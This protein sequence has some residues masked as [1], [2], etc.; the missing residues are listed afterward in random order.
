[1]FKLAA[2]MSKKLKSGRFFSSYEP[3]KKMPTFKSKWLN[4]KGQLQ[5]TWNELGGQWNFEDYYEVNESKLKI[6]HERDW[7]QP[8]DATNVFNER[9]MFIRNIDAPP[10][11]FYEGEVIKDTQIPH[12]RG[13]FYVEGLII[14]EGWFNDGSQLNHDDIARYIDI[15]IDLENR[16]NRVVSIFE[17][18]MDYTNNSNGDFKQGVYKIPSCGKTFTG[19]FKQR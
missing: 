7:I 3:K 4:D 1:M 10:N 17:G 14:R 18:V 9:G 13:I 16:S 8:F 5:E 12:G 2:I 6:Y 15:N 11:I 19:H